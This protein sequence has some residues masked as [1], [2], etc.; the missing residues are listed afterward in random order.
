[1]TD[2]FGLPAHPFL[3]HLPVVLAPLVLLLVIGMAVRP[4][5][6]R[7]YGWLLL[8]GCFVL[9]AGMILATQSG[10][11]LQEALNGVV[12]V[13]KH[14]DLG[15]TTKNLSLLLFLGALVFVFVGRWVDGTARR[16][17]GAAAAV[18]PNWLL[19][20]L[21]GVLSVLSALVVVWTIRTGHEGARVVWDGVLPKK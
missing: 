17:A 1:M 20:V 8:G 15:N 9:V 19:P 10:E 7:R 2:L 14:A 12:K 5:W 16:S 6:R 18:T 21:G 4:L 11:G 3:V 13:D